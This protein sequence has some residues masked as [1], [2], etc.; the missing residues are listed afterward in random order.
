MRLYQVRCS[1]F[2]H[3]W[4]TKVPANSDVEAMD[5]AAGLAMYD[6]EN[7]L[8]VEVLNERD[9]LPES[10]AE[11]DRPGTTRRPGHHDSDD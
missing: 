9:V 3:T 8:I 7:N 11:H 10:G 4:T 6:A 5:S 2:G 1:M